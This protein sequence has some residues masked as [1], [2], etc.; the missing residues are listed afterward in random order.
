MNIR[1]PLFLSAQ[2]CRALLSPADVL[3]A[4]EQA[5]AAD[6]AGS[7]RWPKPRNLNI[8]PDRFGNHYHLK[9]CVLEDVPVAG[10]R[11]VSHPADESSGIATRWVVLIDPQT[12]LPLAIVD[13]RWNY[14]QRT[15]A[16]VALAARKLAAGEPATLALVGAGRLAAAALEYY[17]RLFPLQEVRIAS[18]REETRAAL[19]ARA[20]AAHGLRAHAVPSIEAAVR[21]A[22]L[23]LTCTSAARPLLQP[24]WIAPG[25]VVAALETAEPGRELAEQADLFV[26][27]SR[28]QLEKELIETFGPEG[29]GWV[30]AT[31]GEVIA[32][33]HPGRTD[34]AQRVLIV[35][36]GMASQD[37][38]LAHKAYTLAVSRG[39]G[40][41][42]P[43]MAELD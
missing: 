39:Q 41:A 21:G 31:I 14:A 5:L 11:L 28:E 1:G 22:G 4:C 7:L 23:V 37:V 17:T 29:P 13:E 6:G 30:D 2:E 18:R 38:A 26:V 19:A 16:S 25:A 33:R 40:A 42:L 32:G 9:A 24:E 3:A 8:V 10:I 27:D 12:T 20:A 15:V 43:A 36:Q 34:P 35:T